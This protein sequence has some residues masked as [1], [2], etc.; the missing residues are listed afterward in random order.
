VFVG[1]EEEGEIQ[2]E[3]LAGAQIDDL[4]E[5]LEAGGGDEEVVESGGKPGV[6][7][8]VAVDGERLVGSDASLAA[9]K[10]EGADGAS[11][12]IGNLGVERTS[13]VTRRRSLGADT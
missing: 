10:D 9:E 4:S 5:G 6:E 2:A 7:F 12:F 13:S 3:R 11:V 8:R 1:V